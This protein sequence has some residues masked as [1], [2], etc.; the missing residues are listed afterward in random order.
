VP[1]VLTTPVGLLTQYVDLWKLLSS[2]DCIAS[3]QALIG[4]P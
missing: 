3:H 2:E 1:A 4:C